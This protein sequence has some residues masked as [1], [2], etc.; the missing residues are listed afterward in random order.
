[1]MRNRSTHLLFLRDVVDPLDLDLDRLV[2]EFCRVLVESIV[3][4]K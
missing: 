3:L 1:M 4:A 2:V